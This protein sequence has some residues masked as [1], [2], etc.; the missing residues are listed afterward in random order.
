MSDRNLM[1]A[2][3]GLAFVMLLNIGIGILAYCLKHTPLSFMAML[4]S[5]G[6][7]VPI[8]IWMGYISYDMRSRTAAGVEE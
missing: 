6:L 7:G 8:S 4:M 2:T 3:G 5:V 1:Y